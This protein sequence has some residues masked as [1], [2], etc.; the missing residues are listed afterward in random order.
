MSR[1]RFLIHLKRWSEAIDA[2]MQSMMVNSK[3]WLIWL[4]ANGRL[5]TNLKWG[6]IRQRTVWHGASL[7]SSM[8][9][10]QLRVSVF[11]LFAVVQK[12]TWHLLAEWNDPL[13]GNLMKLLS[14]G[15]VSSFHDPDG[16]NKE[17]LDL[18][19][20]RVCKNMAQ[21]VVDEQLASEW[22]WWVSGNNNRSGWSWEHYCWTM[23]RS[24]LANSHTLKWRRMGQRIWFGH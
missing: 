9:M 5:I 20:K 22:Q 24:V 11:Y 1:C 21:P 6:F 15:G 10:N 23:V 12:P 7:T 8:I 4:L 14:L 13:I 19:W 2:T 16:H 3:L 17:D 18:N